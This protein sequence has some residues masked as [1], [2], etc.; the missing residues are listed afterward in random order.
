[1]VVPLLSARPATSGL[2]ARS[3]ILNTA[4]VYDVNESYDVTP[5][6]ITIVRFNQVTKQSLSAAV[7]GCSWL[8][9]SCL[10]VPVVS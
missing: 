5:K 10:V 3:A 2:D 6:N 9:V 4:T 1:M 7:S 8:F